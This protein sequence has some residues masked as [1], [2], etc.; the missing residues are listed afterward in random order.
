MGILTTPLNVVTPAML[1]LSK[2]VCP[3]TSKSPLIS[4]DVAVTIPVILTPVFSVV[5][6]SLPLK[7][8]F[9]ELS[10][11]IKNTF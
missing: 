9:V 11:S 3:S 6:F 10:A 5:N 7:Y 4:A 1:T 8:N 2:F